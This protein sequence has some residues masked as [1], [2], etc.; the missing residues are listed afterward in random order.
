MEKAVCI[1]PHRKHETHTHT[2]HYTRTCIHY[3]TATH[4]NSQTTNN[5]S[6]RIKH[7]QHFRHQSYVCAW[8]EGGGEEGGWSVGGGCKEQQ[9]HTRVVRM[10]S[11][12]N[13]K[14]E[15]T[16][17]ASNK[18]YTFSDYFHFKSA[19]LMVNGGVY[20]TSKTHNKAQQ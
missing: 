19:C 2:I 10:N 18:S 15:K 6:L 20:Q 4:A 8:E 16:E 13:Y 9:A 17:F 1:L 11:N 7:K 5:T 12:S 3:S 14:H